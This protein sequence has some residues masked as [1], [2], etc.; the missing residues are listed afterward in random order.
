MTLLLERDSGRAVRDMISFLKF[1]MLVLA[2]GLALYLGNVVG[3]A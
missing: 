2:F 1:L 3:H